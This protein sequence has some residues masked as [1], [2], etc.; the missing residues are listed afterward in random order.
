[1]NFLWKACLCFQRIAWRGWS[2]LLFPFLW[3]AALHQA[4]SD[5]AFSTFS[6][7]W[8]PKIPCWGSKQG[9]GGRMFGQVQTNPRLTS[10]NSEVSRRVDFCF[11]TWGVPATMAE[12]SCGMKKALCFV[13]FVHQRKFGLRFFC[14]MDSY[15]IKGRYGWDE[16][17]KDHMR[18]SGRKWGWA[19]LWCPAGQG[20]QNVESV[21]MLKH[22][23]CYDQFAG[24]R[25]R[26]FF[27]MKKCV[28]EVK[29]KVFSDY[30][31]SG[32][33]LF[34]IT[35]GLLYSEILNWEIFCNYY[36]GII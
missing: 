23:I 27:S 11:M 5:S 7:Q 2:S 16:D 21:R 32:C 14:V 29:L 15:I 30:G 25:L 4:E 10:F 18:M 8:G 34:S 33:L 22:K 6:K 36:N 13:R 31:L 3:K 1:M 19:F 17:E 26:N 24:A 28:S 9:C 12:I 35:L 20:L